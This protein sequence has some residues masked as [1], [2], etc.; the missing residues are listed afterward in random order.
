MLANDTDLDGNPLTVI[1]VGGPSNGAVTLNPNG[2]FTYT[3]NANYNGTDTFTYRANDGTVDSNIATVT[4]TITP[5]NDP[6]VAVNDAYTTAEDTPLT[7][8]A[9]GVLANDTDADGNPL[10][11][12]LVGTPAN[13]TVTLNPNGSFT[14]T[15]NANFNGT[16][17]FT[18]RANDGTVDSNIATVT[19]TITPVNDA[20]V[21]VNDA[22]STA[23]D[24]PLTI[25][26][27]GVLANDSDPD[28]NPLTVTLVGAPANGAVTL[29]PN[30]SFT[31]TPNANYNGTDTFTYRANDGTVNSN[32]ATVTITITPVNDPPI[33]ID[34]SY[35][36]AQDTTLVIAAPG[37]ANNDS[38][39]DGDPLTVTPA[40]TPAHGTVAVNPNGSFTYTPTAGYSGTDSFTYSIT[41]GQGGLATAI[42]HLTITPAGIVQPVL[43]ATK[44]AALGVD[45]DGNGVISPGDTIQYTIVVRN[46]GTGPATSVV[47]T[48]TPGANTTLVA[49]SVTTSSGVI[50]SGNGPADTS[51][52]VNIGTLAPGAA[53]TVT[54]RARIASPLPPGVTSVR[55]QGIVNSVETTTNTDDPSTPVVPDP[56]T[57]PVVVPSPAAP[58]S[59]NQQ[60]RR[61]ASAA[62]GRPGDIHGDSHQPRRCRS[63]R[64]DGYGHPPDGHFLRQRLG[65]GRHVQRRHR[66][67]ADRH[68]DGRLLRDADDSRERG[69]RDRRQ[70]DHELRFAEHVRF[71]FSQRPGVHRHHAGDGKNGR[72]RQSRSGHQ[73]SD[74]AGDRSR[75]DAAFHRRGHRS[76]WRQHQPA[77]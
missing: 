20:P 69:R 77:R 70:H 10:T 75:R 13:G 31:Y 3:P 40:T 56:T 66:T 50:T 9:P 19:I 30:G 38:D 51:L 47:L 49:G 7:I 62:R 68:L 46:T 73:R 45:A 60:I 55:N 41:D 17:T 52:T 15:P 33:A 21:A 27:P 2:S 22:Y 65:L 28:G 39:P 4:I 1:L 64:R 5:V 63:G 48:D 58:G 18:Y 57:T 53:V 37:I 6:P 23:E 74:A 14:Y 59:L 43:V 71:E 32:I 44:T 72:V 8:A 54:L 35:T 25:G 16:D 67:L 12:T 29:N 11:V 36:T 42:V 34:D 61:S 76:R 26:A 24:T